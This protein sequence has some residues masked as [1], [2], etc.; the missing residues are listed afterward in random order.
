MGKF[1]S[2]SWW[3]EK[4]EI[5]WKNTLV[6]AAILTG[7]TVV[8]WLYHM[9]SAGT[10]NIVMFYTVALIFLVLSVGHMSHINQLPDFP[11]DQRPVGLAVPGQLGRTKSFRMLS[12]Q[13]YPENVDRLQS[14]FLVPFRFQ[15]LNIPINSADVI[16]KSFKAFCF[17]MLHLISSETLYHKNVHLS[18]IN[19]K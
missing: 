13:I 16:G 8:A 1:C 17:Q 6:T 7:V 15:F 12:E 4:W 18:T 5:T 14:Q 3:R 10:V 11:A 2:R 19:S 9:L